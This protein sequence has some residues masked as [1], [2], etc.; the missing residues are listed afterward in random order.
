MSTALGS[1]LCTDST[2]LLITGDMAFF[3]DRNAFWHQ[4]LPS[5]LKIIVLNNQGGGI[6]RLINGP[7]QQPELEEFFET[8]QSLSARHLA[9]EYGFDYY[10]CN[11]LKS[12]IESFRIF[13]Q[14]GKNVSILEVD[15]HPTTNKNVYDQIM[16]GIS[17]SL[18]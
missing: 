12:L 2:V 14:P 7:G 13:I 11:N 6:F 3:Y 9:S 10:P 15:T 18:N 17:E 4:N 16:S 5:N 1:A 8:K